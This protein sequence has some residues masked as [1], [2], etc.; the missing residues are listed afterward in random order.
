M[1]ASATQ[2]GKVTA[3]GAAPARREL[4]EFDPTRNEGLLRQDPARYAQMVRNVTAYGIY[5]IDRDGRIRSW[6]QG[7]SNITG[8]GEREVMDQAY[9]TLFAESAVREGVPLK[10]L[11]FARSNRHCHEEHPRRRKNGEEF[12]AESTLDAVRD[13]DGQI[14]GFVEVFHDVTEQK[15]REDRLYQRATRDPLTGVYNRGHFTELGAQEMERARR[16]SEP[17]SVALLDIDHFKKVNDTHGHEVG[18]R[19]I[20]ALAKICTEQLRKIDFV[21]RIGGEEFSMVLQSAKMESALVMSYG[22]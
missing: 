20:Q 9:A 17:L 6:N 1:I 10:T 18:D 22:V 12:L 4:G 14:L 7:A 11:N 21:G 15:R 2:P 8:Y 3:I 5:L 13:V 19:A 16:F